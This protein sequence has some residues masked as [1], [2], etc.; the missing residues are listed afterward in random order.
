[1]SY[2]TVVPCH[3]FVNFFFFVYILASSTDNVIN[4][5]VRPPLAGSFSALGV[6]VIGGVVAVVLVYCLKR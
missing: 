1:M 5:D 2:M 4:W 3:I 6:L